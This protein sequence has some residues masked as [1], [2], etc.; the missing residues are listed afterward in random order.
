MT[1]NV[2]DHLSVYPPVDNRTLLLKEEVRA[3]Y[4][5]KAYFVW[6]NYLDIGYYSLV[7]TSASDVREIQSMLKRSG[8]GNLNLSGVYDR[9]T[10]NAVTKFQAM[11]GISQDG[12][13]GPLT[14]MLLYQQSGYFNPP[15]LN[16][17]RQS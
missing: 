12:R 13:V 9:Q 11:Q 8:I 14:L 5:G 17:A 2:E 6:K 16:D 7:G 10:I 1:G 3:L 4:S 15:R